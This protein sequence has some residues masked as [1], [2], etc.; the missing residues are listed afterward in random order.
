MEGKLHAE[1]LE[2]R[3]DGQSV[4]RW[5]FNTRAKQLMT[6]HHQDITTFNASDWWFNRLCSR[7]NVSFRRKTRTSQKPPSKLRACIE[8]FH[9]KAL[10]ERTQGSYNLCDL[11]NMDQ[12]PLPFVL[13]DNKSYDTKGVDEVWCGTGQSGLDKRQCTVQLTVFAHGSTRLPPLIER[14][15]HKC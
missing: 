3:K 4:K 13:E 1:F 6:Q 10:R 8:S 11:A 12:I 5:W 9:A 14:F 2:L 15:A 7:K